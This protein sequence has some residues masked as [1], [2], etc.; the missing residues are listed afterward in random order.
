VLAEGETAA[1]CLD[2]LEARA[3]WVYH[4]GTAA[5]RSAA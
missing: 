1:A 4:T 3:A 5:A 2:A